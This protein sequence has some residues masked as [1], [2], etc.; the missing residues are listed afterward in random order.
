M[1]YL[2]HDQVSTSL[3]GSP[4]TRTNSL[5]FALWM[6]RVGRIGLCLP[7]DWAGA[8]LTHLWVFVCW[9]MH[10]VPPVSTVVPTVESIV[11]HTHTIMKKQ[12]SSIA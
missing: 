4:L 10:T 9:H 7:I 8:M 2:S 3:Y 1:T 5:G 11:A 6:Y 12:I